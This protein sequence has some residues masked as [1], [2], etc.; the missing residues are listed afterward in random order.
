MPKTQKPVTV[1]QLPMHV[2]REGRRRPKAARLPARQ[3]PPGYFLMPVLAW[4]P[5]WQ[6]AAPRDHAG[7][8]VSASQ[9]ASAIREQRMAEGHADAAGTMALPNTP[10]GRGPQWLQAAAGRAGA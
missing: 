8:G 2:V 9:R 10:K 5:D 7:E 3:Y 6:P 1:A 4:W